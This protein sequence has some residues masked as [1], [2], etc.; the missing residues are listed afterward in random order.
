MK[1]E[2]LEVSGWRGSIKGMRNPLESWARSDTVWDKNSLIELGAND[3]DLMQR[4]IKAGAEHRKFLRYIHVQFDMTA[5]LYLWKEFDTYKVSTTANSTSTMHK[6]SSKPITID[7]F[8]TDDYTEE[9]LV[10]ENEP[11]DIDDSIGNC[12]EDIINIC[13]TLRK[14]YLETK[15][16][17]YWKELVRWLPESW[18]QTRT[19]DLNYEV[20]RT[21]VHQRAGHKLTE[22]HQ[23]IDWVHTLPY[24]DELIFYEN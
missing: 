5:P 20:L 12:A 16:T 13:E 14:R 1:F 15:D 11:Y 24:A 21:I 3:L 17:R 9:L 6:L 23:F 7:C 10:Y 18:L 2:T 4:L 8:E 22:W 19:I